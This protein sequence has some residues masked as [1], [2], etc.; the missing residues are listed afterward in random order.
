MFN[1]MRSTLFSQRRDPSMEEVRIRY[2]LFITSVFSTICFKSRLSSPCQ[3]KGFISEDEFQLYIKMIKYQV[4]II[5]R[6]LFDVLI[7]KLFIIIKLILYPF[8]CW[9]ILRLLLYLSFYK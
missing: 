5:F 9:W 4:L 8:I 1:S 6:R 2:L 3:Q 7:I